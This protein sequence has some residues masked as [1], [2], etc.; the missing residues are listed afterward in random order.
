MRRSLIAGLALILAGCSNGQ[1][2]PIVNA[3]V[4][5]VLPGEAAPDQGSGAAPTA[6]ESRA[7]IQRADV[8][9]IR[10]RLLNDPAPTFLFAASENGGYVTYASSIR[11]TLTLR[12][13]QITASRGLGWDLLSA[14]SSRPDPLVTPMRPGTWPAQVQRSYEF[15]A[16]APQGRIET[17]DC[18]F[19][20][21]EAQDVVILGV[22]HRGVAITETC[23]NDR[24]NFENLHLADV[25]TGF[26][27][28]SIQWLGP[29]QGLVDVEIVL[30]FTGRR[31]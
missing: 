10:A 3:V 25:D 4:T 29:Q 12:G 30:P 9:T 17:F 26:V 14:T 31:G 5:E 1:F 7:S 8:A 22:L 2:N 21:G 18:R 6:A 20:Y 16:F 24:T 13:S 15:P 28:R 27:W 19:E 23:A 11:Q